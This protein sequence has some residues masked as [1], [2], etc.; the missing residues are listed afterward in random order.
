MWLLETHGLKGVPVPNMGT[1]LFGSPWV[2]ALAVLKEGPNYVNQPLGPQVW[3][4]GQVW[5]ST[6]QI[7]GQGLEDEPDT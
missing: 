7:L 2:Q 1:E 5:S 6:T 3:S 4:E